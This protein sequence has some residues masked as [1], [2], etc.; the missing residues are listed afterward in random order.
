VGFIEV[1][2]R[3]ADA[4]P[5]DTVFL[6]LVHNYERSSERVSARTV[7]LQANWQRITLP[8]VV[9]NL[10]GGTFHLVLLADQFQ[11]GEAGRFVC[12]NVR[13]YHATSPHSGVR[14]GLRSIG[15]QDA[16]IILGRDPE[17]ISCA[18]KLTADRTL[19]FATPH[20]S[21]K[22]LPGTRYRISRSGP[23]SV[24]LKVA[25]IASLAASEWCEV[26]HDGTA[27]RLTAK[28]RLN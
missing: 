12:G 14:E 1:E 2:L 7:R 15:D 18:A 19:T 11:K 27:Y 17:Q 20:A 10:D 8:F 23:G 24:I 3:R 9:R 26:T 21:I 6:W 13:V 5:L 25:D 28:G 4:A 22:P 16:T